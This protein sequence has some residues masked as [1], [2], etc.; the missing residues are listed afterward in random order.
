L[1]R[2]AALIP[3]SIDKR[4]TP[5]ASS[6]DRESDTL[7]LACIAEVT[8]IRAE[9]SQWRNFVYS[10]GNVQLLPDDWLSLGYDVCDEV[11]LSGLSNC[12][13]GRSDGRNLDGFWSLALNEYHLFTRWQDAER[14]CQFIDDLVPEHAPFFVVHLFGVPPRPS[15]TSR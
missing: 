1:L 15:S 2:K 13:A 10:R 3:L 14:F 9:Q 7:D 8:P 4:V 5:E 6:E 11:F 12:A